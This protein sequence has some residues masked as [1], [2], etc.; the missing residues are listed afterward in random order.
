M[1]AKG[2]RW[3]AKL[4]YLEALRLLPDNLA[5][6]LDYFRVF[7]RFPDLTN[8]QLFSEKMQHLKLAHDVRTP[9]LGA[10]VR[11]KNYVADTLGERWLIP[12]LWHGEHLTE[13][14]LESIPKPAV[15][16]ANH[17][18]AQVMFLTANSNLKEAARTAN[19][20]RHYD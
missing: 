2:L 20:W 9:D 6:K 17:S 5:V 11:V 16:K 7:G 3:A 10:K 4:A 1:A 12:T 19:T 13:D 18:S 15:V 14:V 8:P